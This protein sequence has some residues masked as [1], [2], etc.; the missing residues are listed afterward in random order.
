MRLRDQLTMLNTKCTRNERYDSNERT[1]RSQVKDIS[2][3]GRQMSPKHLFLTSNVPLVFVHQHGAI[4]ET[5]KQLGSFKKNE[6]K[7]KI[8]RNSL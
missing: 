6:G 4:S 2:V 7:V 1:I 3:E 8:K 5:Q